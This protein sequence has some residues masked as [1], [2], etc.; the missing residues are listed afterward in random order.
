MESSP[1]S[2]IPHQT[3]A[4]GD[5]WGMG[6]G[7]W[8][9]QAKATASVDVSR[10]GLGV[11]KRGGGAVAQ[12]RGT[13]GPTQR[14]HSPSNHGGHGPTPGGSGPSKGGTQSGGE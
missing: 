6:A 10:Q 5:C 1:R 12:R 14:G 4:A 8:R 9:S 11:D 7:Q 3:A 13:R 2:L